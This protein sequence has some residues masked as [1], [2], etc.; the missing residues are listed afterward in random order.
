MSFYKREPLDSDLDHE[1]ED[2]TAF[3]CACG[4]EHCIG[5]DNDPGNLNLGGAWYAADCEMGRQLE[6]IAQGRA[7]AA[8]ADEGRDDMNERRR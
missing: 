5:H 6:Q 1:P 3:A 8:R 4:D 7:Q 2:E